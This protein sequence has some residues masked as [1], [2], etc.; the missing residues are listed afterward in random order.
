MATKLGA[1]Y[2]L[3]KPFRPSELLTAVAKSLGH[4]A[5]APNATSGC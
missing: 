5:S 1:V 3:Q 4:S 2:S